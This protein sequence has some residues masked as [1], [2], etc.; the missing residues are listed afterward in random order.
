MS[1]RTEAP[2]IARIEPLRPRGLRV[3]L[4]LAP[5]EP[6]EV[7]L[8]ALERSRLGVGDPLPSNLRHHLLDADADVRVRDAAL[9]LLSHR[10]RTRSELRRRL[11]AKGFRPARVDTCLDVLET[12]GLLDDDAVAAAFVRDR[13]RYRPRGRLR[14]AAELRTLGIAPESAERVVRRVLEDENVGD[15]E[16]ARRVAA[17]WLSRQGPAVRGALG[18]EPGDPGHRRA[19]TRLYAYLARRGFRG[20]ALRDAM[21]AV[22]RHG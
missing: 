14:L 15:A 13:L 2:L 17:G 6:L 4:H 22:L 20:E 16:L 3:R 19:R 18:R 10:P 9:S 5:G 1:R 12:R 11:L 8:E 7:S 21:D